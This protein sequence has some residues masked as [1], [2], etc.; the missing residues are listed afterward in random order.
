ME[1]HREN[2]QREWKN[3]HI[4]VSVL[5]MSAICVIIVA[6]FQIL[7][8]SARDNILHAWENSVIQLARS[9][10]YYLARPA[11]AIEFSAANVE[12]LMAEGRTNQEIGAYLVREMNHVA[13]LVENNYTGVYG[14]CRG[15]Y[16]D[17][18]GWVPGE[19]YEPTRRPWYIAAKAHPGK[20]TLVSPFL[21]LQTHEMTMSIS[22]LLSD[23]ES[24]LSIDIYMDG[25]QRTLDDLSREKGV[26]EAFLVDSDGV[27]VAHSNRQETGKNYRTGGTPRQQELFRRAC[28]IADREGYYETD[29]LD[30]QLV[31]AERISGAWCAVVVLNETSLLGSARHLNLILVLILLLA[32]LVWYGIFRQI[33]R[34]YREAEQLSREVNAVADIYQSMML[35]DLKTDRMTVLRSSDGMEQALE[36]DFTHFTRR[37]IPL[38]ERVSSDETREM[39]AQF[40]NPAT[41]EER[42]QDARSISFD[43]LSTAGQWFR[44][45]I[46]VV[47]RDGAGHLRHILCAVESIDR[48]RKRQERLRVLAEIDALSGLYNRRA[49]ESRLRSMLAGDSRGTF[50]LAD[51]DSFKSINDNFGHAAGDLVIA[52]VADCLRRTFREGDIVFRLGGDEFAAYV[53][54]AVGEEDAG[55][56]ARRLQREVDGIRI[57][58]LGGQRVSVSIGA[59]RYGGR[60]RDSFEALY[61]RSDAEMYREKREKKRRA[62]RA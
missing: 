59:A 18:S 36:G 7:F 60:D 57:P 8:Q 10:E 28:A 20:V 1:A 19:G 14:Y 24:V 4:L 34:K 27:V 52:A 32:I 6:L 45:Q 48:E 11:D 50:L 17:A 61:Q 42:L 40:V 25:L 58:E 62:G 16:L 38:A 49:G 53:P 31:F 12:D 15:E 33:N 51:I 22:K 41:Y 2:P 46:I 35:V 26:Q 13:S 47:D 21:N 5:I 39:L 29:S 55:Q 44:I 9:T 54:G 30:G 3:G 43:F 23:G 56:L 37:V